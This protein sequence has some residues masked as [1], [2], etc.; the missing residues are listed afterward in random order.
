MDSESDPEPQGQEPQPQPVPQAVGQTPLSRSQARCVEVLCEGLPSPPPL[1]QSAGRVP[2]PKGKG[3]SKSPSRKGSP[4][5]SRRIR[6][7][8]EQSAQEAQARAKAELSA[9]NARTYT[10]CQSEDSDSSS[11]GSYVTV[12]S[13]DFSRAGEA[14]AGG[15][16]TGVWSKAQDGHKSPTP[17]HGPKPARAN[18]RG[19][20]S[21]GSPTR[22][23]GRGATSPEVFHHPKYGSDTGRQSK[24]GSAAGG[25][26][27]GRSE[28]R[29]PRRREDGP[30]PAQKK[31][32][33]GGW[34]QEG[35]FWSPEARGP[36]PP[37]PSQPEGAERA[38][39]FTTSSFRGFAAVRAAAVAKSDERERSKEEHREEVHAAQ[40]KEI[41][42]QI[43]SQSEKFQVLSEAREAAAAIARDR[44]Q[45]QC[46]AQ[47]RDFARERE[48]NQ[49]RDRMRDERERAQDQL[50][51]E[52]FQLIRSLQEQYTQRGSP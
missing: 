5:K 47:M 20:K 29:S 19:K 41:Q 16:A 44:T 39:M 52:Q 7:G 23:T 11:G 24:M 32:K 13:G 34:R 17:G 10:P 15:A 51:Q 14:R 4:R 12:C 25:S 28:G 42:D 45:A 35:A 40:V 48:R 49:E 27:Q 6:K 46:V 8:A 43:R 37:A 26:A 50:V 1:P 30:A 31:P 18:K 36:R 22:P 21:V 33:A 3:G 2:P 38:R 9:K